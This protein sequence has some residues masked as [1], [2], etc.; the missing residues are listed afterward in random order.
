MHLRAG[1]A[2]TAAGKSEQAAAY[3]R[4]GME[5]KPTDRPLLNELRV[6]AASVYSGSGTGFVV[7]QGGYLLTNHHV[8]RGPGRIVVRVHPA[9][10]PI[11]ATVIAQ[12]EQ[13]DMALIRLKTSA[14]PPLR[15]LHLREANPLHRGDAVAALGYP[16]GDF[17]GSSLKITTGVISATE[18]TGT[19]GL[20]M[21]DAKVNPGNSGGPLCDQ[22]GNVVGMISAKSFAVGAIESYGMAIPAQDLDAFLKKNLKEYKPVA[23][24]TQKLAWNEVDALVSPAV[25]M[26]LKTR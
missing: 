6:R 22:A 13:R 25:M 18:D 3:Y 8:I 26:V 16:L 24:A 9:K 2:L 5:F 1:E 19:D 10:E 11:E 20:L 23:A 15:P 12:D 4:Q 14:E 7:S 17:M 21:L